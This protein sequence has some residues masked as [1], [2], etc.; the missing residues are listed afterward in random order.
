MPN[1]ENFVYCPE[2]GAEV[3]LDDPPPLDLALDLEDAADGLLRN[4]TGGTPSAG[5]VLTLKT[6]I[7]DALLSMGVS[8]G[9]LK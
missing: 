2:C 6:K 3:V 8:E 7:K 9:I 4:Y 5:D 1:D